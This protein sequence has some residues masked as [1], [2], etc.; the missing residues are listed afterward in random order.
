VTARMPVYRGV[1]SVDR[2]CSCRD[3]HG[4]ALGKNCPKLAR[5]SHGQW[6]YRLELPED[7][8]GQRRP[9]R[10]S[11]FDSQTAAQTELDR[12]RELLALPEDGDAAALCAVGDLIAEALSQKRPLPE[13]ATV[14]QLLRA[15]TA[16]LTHPTVGQWLATWLVGKKNIV[17]NTYRSYDSHIRLYLDRY[18]GKLRLD[19]LRVEHVSDM[20]DMIAE[21][22]DEI[23]A[24]RESGDPTR[25][26]AVRYQRP[27][28]STSM[29]RIRATLRTALNDAIRRELITFNAAKWVELPAGN[30]PP[31]LVWTP[32]RIRRWETSG[33]VPSPVM[34]WTPA[35][36]G[37]FLDHILGDRLYAL[38]HLVAH[39]GLRRGEACGLRWID[40]D[41]SLHPD[42]G[43]AIGTIHVLNQIVQLGWATEQ[44]TPKTDESMA[45]VALD[46]ATTVEL[47]EHRDRQDTERHTAISSGDTWT[48]TGMVFTDTDGSELH[49]AAV[50]SR[51]RVLLTR[52]GLPPIRLHDLRHGAATT[53]LAAGVDMKVVQAMLRHANITTTSN[54]YTNVLPEVAQA[55]AI[56][57]AA[58]IPRAPRRVR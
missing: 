10:R 47:L 3:T 28:G 4:K 49:P 19:K 16:G 43:A 5:S 45:T 18:L 8:D 24:A 53:A 26:E 42:K 33:V 48:E 36:T 31:P 21:Y 13:V 38:F 32:E 30:R 14:R 22:N 9:R 6:F 46:P 54:L 58:A 11:G 27:V 39:C 57:I 17:P 29:Q 23:R 56:N 40:T 12:A 15:G 51:F 41:L 44:S 7:A 37:K 50:T 52:A 55:A 25:C 2:R 1:G 34:V 20:F 35:Q